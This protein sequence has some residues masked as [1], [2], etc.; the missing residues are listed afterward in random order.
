MLF[1]L[2][3]KWHFFYLLFYWVFHDF[4]SRWLVASYKYLLHF[5]NIKKHKAFLP[6][7]NS[8][9]AST[10]FGVNCVLQGKALLDLTP[11]VLSQS[12]VGH[13]SI[14]RCNLL[15]SIYSCKHYWSFKGSRNFLLW[16]HRRLLQVTQ[17]LYAFSVLFLYSSVSQNP[18]H[19]LNDKIHFI[20]LCVIWFLARSSH[21]FTDARSS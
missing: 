8:K 17:V 14:R 13:I 7:K 15:D 16:V 2:L 11:G 19:K 1:W 10:K 4:L 18:L 6:S 21:L 12:S 9:M 20:S 5:W 3:K